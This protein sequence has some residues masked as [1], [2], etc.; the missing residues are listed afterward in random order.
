MYSSINWCETSFSIFLDAQD[1]AVFVQPD[2]RFRKI[3]VER[4]GLDAAAADFCASSCA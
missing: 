1:A 2:F 3:Q 4:A